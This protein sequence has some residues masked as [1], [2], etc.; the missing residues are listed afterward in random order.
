MYGKDESI[1]GISICLF[2]DTRTYYSESKNNALNYCDN[3]NDLELKDNKWIYA[4]VVEENKKIILE[5]PLQFDIIN[6][7]GDSG[8][9]RVLREVS[10]VDLVKALKGVDE[11]TKE[12]VFKNISKRAS[13]ML[14]E[15]LE[16]AREID[17][18][19]V[20]S[21]RKRILEIIRGLNSSG[22]I[23]FLETI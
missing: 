14:K 17:K 4:S 8:L 12:K 19:A 2:D 5:K 11:R 6:K 21:A 15:D 23:I 20:K 22:E 1:E 9:Q 3:I 13:A 10:S 7:L 16:L 18:D